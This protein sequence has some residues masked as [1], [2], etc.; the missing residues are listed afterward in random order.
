MTDNAKKTH[1]REDLS[2]LERAVSDTIDEWMMRMHGIVSN[3]A[4]PREFIGWLRERGY[5][6]AP[7]KERDDDQSV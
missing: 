7:C 3:W 6:I 4:Y 2:P 1:R 5:E